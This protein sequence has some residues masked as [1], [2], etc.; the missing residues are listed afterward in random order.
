MLD[1]KYTY[2][3]N[4]GFVL[5]NLC[6]KDS[7]R[8]KYGTTHKQDL[9]QQ[10]KKLNNQLDLETLGQAG[11]YVQCQTTTCQVRIQGLMPG[12]LR[13]IEKRVACGHSKRP[14]QSRDHLG[15]SCA[16][17]LPSPSVCQSGNILRPIFTC[18]A[19][20]SDEDSCLTCWHT[21]RT[22]LQKHKHSAPFH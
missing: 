22:L 2:S 6:M 13:K 16:D 4:K 12:S 14:R 5:S 20:V 17:W 15:L 1:I 10:Q 21:V 18:A 9:H 11:C 3:G 7:A 19:L 8:R